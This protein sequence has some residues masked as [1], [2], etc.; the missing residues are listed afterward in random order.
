MI[1]NVMKN[2]LYKSILKNTKKEE[3]LVIRPI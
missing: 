2:K 1:C 3:K